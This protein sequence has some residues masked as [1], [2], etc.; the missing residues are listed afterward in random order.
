MQME[1]LKNIIQKK[2]E[3][4]LYDKDA[5]V[6]AYGDAEKNHILSDKCHVKIDMEE[7]C[8]ISVDFMDKMA[9]YIS[10]YSDLDDAY[11]D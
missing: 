7:D 4:V 11:S 8:D 3:V 10:L 6:L 2:T 1:M 5:N 9:M